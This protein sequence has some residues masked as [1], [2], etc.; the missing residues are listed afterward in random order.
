MCF[1]YFWLWSDFLCR[2]CHRLQKHISLDILILLGATSGDVGRRRNT[3]L[4]KVATTLPITDDVEAMIL[5]FLLVRF[6]VVGNAAG[7]CDLGQ[8]PRVSHPNLF[9]LVPATRRRELLEMLGD[10]I[11]MKNEPITLC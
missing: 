2:H 10:G 9:C 1:F 11:C 5:Q 4:H 6:K 3:T 8:L 7:F